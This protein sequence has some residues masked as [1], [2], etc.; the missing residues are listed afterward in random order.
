MAAKEFNEFAYWF[1]PKCNGSYDVW[2]IESHTNLGDINT[3]SDDCVDYDIMKSDYDEYVNRPEWLVGQPLTEAMVDG[4]T[5]ES[6]K[7][8]YQSLLIGIAGIRS[9]RNGYNPDESFNKIKKTL[10]WLD[11]TDF[12]TAPASTMFHESEPHGLLHHSLKVVAE[13]KQLAKLPKFSDKVKIED[14]TLVALTHDWC[15]IGLYEM[16][17]RN[18]KNENGQWEQ[19]PS[20]K[21]K[22]FVLPMGHG[23][24][25]MWQVSKCFKLTNYEALALRW[26]MGR[27]NVADNEINELQQSNENYPLVHLLQFADQLAITKY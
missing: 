9:F 10:D 6:A 2:E 21:R 19:V 27:W 12:Y 5:P 25:S 23:A 1:T 11:S 18:Q 14:A 22:D 20:Y 16:Y 24:S 15:K 7:S 17:M 13:I 4:H 26:H 3:V 8:L